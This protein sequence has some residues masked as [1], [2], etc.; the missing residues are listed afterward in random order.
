MK[1]VAWAGV[2]PTIGLRAL[3]TYACPAQLRWTVQ[4]AHAPS[5]VTQP[6]LHRTG[7]AY[8]PPVPRS[9]PNHTCVP[10]TFRPHGRLKPNSEP[11]GRHGDAVSE[12][13]SPTL[14]GTGGVG[15]RAAALR[16]PTV[17]DCRV[18]MAAMRDFD[19]ANVE[20][21]Q[22]PPRGRGSTRSQLRRRF[23]EE[24]VGGGGSRSLLPR[25]QSLLEGVPAVVAQ[26]LLQAT[27]R[28]MRAAATAHSVATLKT[29]CNAWP[30]TQLSDGA[31]RRQDVC[32]VG[33]VAGIAWPTFWCDHAS[34]GRYAGDSA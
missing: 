26:G 31:F 34:G 29:G 12:G 15:G 1:A 10:S 33:D 20:L 18:A 22:Q 7:T 3:L 8:A 30:T 13:R 14:G 5:P 17:A 21:E 2:A 32:I 28:S 11:R 27:T 19:S 16:P 4:Q 6:L 24:A 9:A 25:L 23:M